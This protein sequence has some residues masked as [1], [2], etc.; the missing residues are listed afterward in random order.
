MWMNTGCRSVCG[1]HVDRLFV[2]SDS[3]EEGVQ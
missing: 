2:Y 3:E 1:G